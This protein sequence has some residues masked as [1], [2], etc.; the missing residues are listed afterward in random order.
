MASGKGGKGRGGKGGKGRGGKGNRPKQK[1][2]FTHT[3]WADNGD[4]TN[5][6]STVKRAKPQTK[7]PPR[8]IPKPVKD[9]A[10]SAAPFGIYKGKFGRLEAKR[11]LDRAGFG[12]KPGEAS[13]LAAMG[14]RKAVQSLTRPQG[15]AQLIGPAPHDDDGNPLAPTDAWGHDHL[16]WLDRMVRSDQPLVE[17]LTLILHDWFATSTE[18][19]S[20]TEYL[21]EQNELFRN[22]CLGSFKDLVVEVTKN[23]AM[24]EWL[25]GIE[26]SRWAPNENFARELQELFTLGADRGAYS[27]DD[28][29]EAARALTGWDAE[30]VDD[31]GFDDFRYVPSRHDSGTKTI[32]GKSGNFDWTDVCRMVIEHPLHPSFFVTKLWSYFIPQ[33]P[34]SSTRNELIKIYKSS[35]YQ[36]RPVVEAILMHPDFYR[37]PRQVKPPV[38]YLASL[39][40]SQRRG[41]E[42]DAWSW[43]C[44]GAG[45]R[46]FR[47]PNV[48]GWDDSRWLDTSTMRSRWHF[49][50]YIHYEHEIDPWP[51][52]E[53]DYYPADETPEQ[54]VNNALRYWDWPPL[55]AD[56]RNELIAFAKN[57]FP[58]KL[59]DWEQSPYRALRQ[60]ALR[61]LI[62]MSPDFHLM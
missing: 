20:R 13:R 49:F 1:K 25:N 43:L 29:R 42:T 5:R 38:V 48:S 8:P 60:N 31:Y 30:W 53:D 12:A 58:T 4:G 9:Y 45:Q 21:L 10:A 51:D 15:N 7:V 54:A 3:I 61:H 55:A 44:E 52:D 40:R 33:A 27:E 59:E 23:R 47:P 11:L 50:T 37:G 39:L 57:A 2:R 56:H 19:V 17:R 46:L 41:V 35:N 62:A 14:L 22:R 26:N 6:K 18:N 36:I 32:Y 28:I 34:S 24:L 16:W